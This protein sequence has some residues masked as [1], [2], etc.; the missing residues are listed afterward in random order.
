MIT[1]ALGLAAQGQMPCIGAGEGKLR[2]RTLGVE[3]ISQ[4]ARG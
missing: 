3:M 2:A 4:F 1:V